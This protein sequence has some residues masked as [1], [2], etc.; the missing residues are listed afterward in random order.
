MALWRQNPTQL[1]VAYKD[2]Q[3]RYAD[4]RAL[5]YT[6]ATFP[7]RNGIAQRFAMKLMR[8]SDIKLTAKVYTDETQLPI[9]DAVKNLPRLG[10]YTQRH[11]QILG[12][13]GQNVARPGA[14]CEGTKSDK[15]LV[16]GGVCLGQ[17]PLHAEKGMERAK[18]FESWFGFPDGS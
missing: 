8:H 3:G 16:N 17:A 14:G 1:G 11:A 4:F 5:R 6:W 7:Q 12:A 15:T 10:N 2:E 9:Y 18:G 13:E